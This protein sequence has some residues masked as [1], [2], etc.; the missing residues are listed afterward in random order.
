MSVGTSFIEFTILKVKF[1]TNEKTIACKILQQQKNWFD[2]TSFSCV[3]LHLYWKI[4]IHRVK[5]SNNV[6]KIQKTRNLDGNQFNILY[7]THCSISCRQ[8]YSESLSSAVMFMTFHIEKKDRKIWH[9]NNTM[10][11]AWFFLLA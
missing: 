10:K 9:A 3:D 2:K 1:Q 6:T 4:K 5:W 8:S 11:I 7:S